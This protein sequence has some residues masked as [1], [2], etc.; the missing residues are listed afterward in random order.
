MASSVSLLI[1]MSTFAPPFSSIKS[2]HLSTA[3]MPLP[4]LWGTVVAMI[5]PALFTFPTNTVH[6]YPNS[7]PG[8]Q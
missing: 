7:F 2:K 3:N 5:A 4:P 6:L 8:K 1:S